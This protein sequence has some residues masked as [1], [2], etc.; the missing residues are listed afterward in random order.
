MILQNIYT[1]NNKITDLLQS[2]QPAS[3]IRLDNTAGYILDCLFKE[4]EPV[5]QF[6]NPD[7]FLQ[8]GMYPTTKE[9]YR[10]QIIP[11]L[12]KTLHRADILGVVDISNQIHNSNFFDNF[13]NVPYKFA[14]NN[15]H[16]VLDPGGLM[17]HSPASHFKLDNPWTKFLKGKKV[18]AI[19][20]HAE[21]IKQ[22][23]EKID[24]IWGDDR[25]LI[26]PFEFVDCIRS[27]YHPYMDD[28][29]PPNCEHWLQSVEFI[30]KHMDNYDYDVLL[31]GCSSSAPFY[32]NHAKEKGKIGI[33][34]GGVLQLYFGILGYRWTKVPGHS[35]WNNMYND[36]WMYPLKVD[37]ANNKDTKAA[38]ETNFAYW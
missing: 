15:N 36:H 30:C 10:N 17:G 20:T 8:G 9:Y 33:Q 28:R 4:Q 34:V 31:A 5:D 23:W 19:S 13:K 26:A 22:Q 16:Y 25:E 18:L 21:T 27:P 32:V 38:L 1:I 37:E 14:G 24:D 12:V 2:N 29:Q 3:V 7:V 6:Y 11:R 35:E